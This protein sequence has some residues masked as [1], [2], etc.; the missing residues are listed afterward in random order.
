[1]CKYGYTWFIKLGAY[2]FYRPNEEIFKTYED[3]CKDADEFGYSK[4]YYGVEYVED[5]DGF[6]T[7]LKHVKEVDKTYWITY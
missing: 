2:G 5:D 6:I 3:A 1:M 4:E 7:V